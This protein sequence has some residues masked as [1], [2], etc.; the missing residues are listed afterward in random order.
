[1]QAEL[2]INFFKGVPRESSFFMK[3]HSGHG[4]APLK[5]FMVS[6]VCTF[7][8]HQHIL[9]TIVYWTFSSSSITKMGTFL[10]D[11]QAGPYYFDG[12]WHGTVL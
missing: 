4:N 7:F 10:K 5:E 2:T 8:L 11:D 3:N 6:L 1:M 9:V 12:L